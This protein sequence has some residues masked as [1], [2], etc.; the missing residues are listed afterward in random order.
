MDI[1]PSVIELIA[2][3]TNPRHMGMLIRMCKFMSLL[4]QESELSWFSIG[5]QICGTRHWEQGLKCWNPKESP[6]S[7]TR[8][9]M[10]PWL[11]PPQ[12]I[13][14]LLLPKDTRVWR[15]DLVEGQLK[16]DAQTLTA[17]GGFGYWFDDNP[18]GNINTEYCIP[19]R[20]FDGVPASDPVNYFIDLSISQL[21]HATAHETMISGHQLTFHFIDDPDSYWS[22]HAGVVV[23]AFVDVY[24]DTG[25]LCFFST[26][27]RRLIH[28]IHV[29]G[30]NHVSDRIMTSRPGEMWVLETWADPSRVLYY[31]PAAK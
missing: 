20:P 5:K 12:I 2:G 13:D 21:I 22:L 11:Q 31:G 19:A 24:N 4:L 15:I 8:R 14:L 16:I 17:E 25:G 27:S 26:R 7:Y 3:Y 28:F 23:A 29:P 1:P 10:C 6:R 18:L 30:E 9:M